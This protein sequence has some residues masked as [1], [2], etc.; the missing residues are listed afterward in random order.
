MAD[1]MYSED[2]KI[3]DPNFY[4]KPRFERYED[5]LP[6]YLPVSIIVEGS[7]YT[8]PGIHS[9]L[10][11]LEIANDPFTVEDCVKKCI[12]VM[13]LKIH[14]IAKLVSVSRGS[15]DLHRKG[16]NIK[17]M[18]PYEE[19]FTFTSEIERLYGENIK[20]GMR[21]ILV[22]RKTLVQHLLANVGQFDSVT[23]YF[24]EVASK[25]NLIKIESVPVDR[26]KSNTRTSGIA[27]M[28]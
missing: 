21:N 6:S 17:D 20:V 3:F 12:E 5:N 26:F 25:L 2:G 23:P 9:S 19:L 10:K 7:K 16:G 4:T 11:P 14:E 27:K 28:A 24:N 13:G 18:Q 15:L 1:L 22:E 8:F